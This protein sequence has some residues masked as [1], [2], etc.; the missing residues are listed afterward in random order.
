M[1]SNARE[2]FPEPLSPV[3][4]TSSF[5]GIST[6][7]FFRLFSL[8]PLIFINCLGCIFTAISIPHYLF[9]FSFYYLILPAHYTIKHDVWVAY[10]TLY[11]YSTNISVFQTFVLFYRING[12]LRSI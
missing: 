3:S 7:R 12:I 5:L 10:N 6:S 9:V 11:Q 4:T 1:V 2:L 8:A